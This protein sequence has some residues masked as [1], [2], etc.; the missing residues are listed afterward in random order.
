MTIKKLSAMPYAQACVR[1]YDNGMIVLQSYSTDV[2][3]IDEN[4]FMECTGTYS[5]TTIR[6]ISA[7]MREYGH[8]CTYYTAKQL[9]LTGDKM[10][11]ITGEV[12]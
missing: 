7:F 3:I 5:R 8:G 4:G 11:L 10:N 2:I 1:I 6:H 9:Y 12:L